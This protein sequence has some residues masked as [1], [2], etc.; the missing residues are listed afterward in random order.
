MI[1]HALRNCWLVLGFI[2]VWVQAQEW[3]THRFEPYRIE[4]QTPS[5]WYIT[6]NRDFDKNY[7]ECFSP[8]ESMYFFVTYSEN[9]KE[10]S[11]EVILSYLKVT[12]ANCDFT[13][14]EEKTINKINFRFTAGI[15]TLDNFQTFIKLGVGNYKNHVYLIDSGYNDLA[16]EEASRTLNRIIDSIKY[17]D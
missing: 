9:E 13:L 10:S 7:I 2:P 15:S 17:F 3:E 11:N 6:V 12:Y 16:N 1:G 14:D 4:F 8:D 5:D